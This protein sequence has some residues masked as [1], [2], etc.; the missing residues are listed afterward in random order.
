MKL[1][2]FCMLWSVFAMGLTSVEIGADTVSEAWREHI[3]R[4]ESIADA[5][6][7]L[8]RDPSDPRERAELFGFLYSQISMAYFGVVYGDAE[9]PDFWPGFHEVFP[10]AWPNPDDVT[11]WVPIDDD[12]VYRIAGHRGSVR[13]L[14]FQVNAG[15]V[16]KYGTGRWGPTLV[17]YDADDLNIGEDGWFEVVLSAERPDG[18]R[19]DWWKLDPG[20]NYIFVRQRAYDWLK[21]IDARFGIERLDR[22]AIQPR[23]TVDQLY[24]RM[25]RIPD[26]AENWTR[27]AIA[28]ANTYRRDRE[29][30]RF[31]PIHLG[32]MGGFEDKVQ[33]YPQAVF[34][35]RADEALIVETE[36]PEECR[37]WNF[38]LVDTFWRTMGGNNQFN[39]INAHQAVVDSDGKFRFVVSATDPGVPNWLDNM[40]N[41][42]G[43]VYGRWNIC[44]S[45]PIP[46]TRKVKVADIRNHLP[47]DTPEVSAEMRDRLLRNRRLGAQLRRRW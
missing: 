46:G 25:G 17:N 21:E 40:G 35:L 12:G 29:P 4:L 26:W 44:S 30:N 9:Y 22:P 2:R 28:G 45:G 47:S 7:K 24:Q 6:S 5:P 43:F 39:S 10:V 38:Q 32:D 19:G 15:K 27:L 1:M 34:E 33:V 3:Q 42:T 41:E 37:Y 23:Y 14:D 16:G 11:Y 20:A 31:Y 18:Y 13:L 36:I 8:L